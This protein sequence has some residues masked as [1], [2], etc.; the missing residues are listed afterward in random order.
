MRQQRLALAA[1]QA[2]PARVGWQRHLLAAVSASIFKKSKIR[3]LGDVGLVGYAVV[4][5]D[6]AEAPQLLDD[7][8]GRRLLLARDSLMPYL[9]TPPH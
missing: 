4:A 2:R 6:V 5:Q 9:S 1:G 3:Q 8:P 7:V